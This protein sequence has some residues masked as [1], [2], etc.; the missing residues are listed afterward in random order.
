VSLD[1]VATV[2]SNGLSC[3]HNYCSTQLWSS[4]G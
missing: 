3:Q 2:V 1:S 4:S